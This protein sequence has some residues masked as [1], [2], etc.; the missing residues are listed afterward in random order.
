LLDSHR[1]LFYRVFDTEP[2]D[3][4]SRPEEEGLYGPLVGWDLPGGFATLRRLIGARMGKHGK[5]EFVQVLRLL[6]VYCSLH[7]V[8]AIFLRRQTRS[9]LTNV[10]QA[11]KPLAY[12]SIAVGTPIT[13]RPP[14][15]TVRAAFL[16]TA[17]TSD[18]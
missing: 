9:V 4:E 7:G 14:H 3:V 16:H 11:S 12:L 15:R 13:G 5:R 17:P 8:S 2:S 6:G 18:D 1:S 10:G